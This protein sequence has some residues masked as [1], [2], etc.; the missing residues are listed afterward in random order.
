MIIQ[1]IG[2]HKKGNSESPR[3]WQGREESSKYDKGRKAIF[4]E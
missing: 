3:K 4:K 2:R 1:K